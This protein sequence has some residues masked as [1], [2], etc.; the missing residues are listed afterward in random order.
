MGK[1]LS[2]QQNE[3]YQGIDQILFEE[4]DPIGIKEF[5]GPRDEYYA[6]LPLVFNLALE[7]A[8]ELQIAEYLCNYINENIGLSSSVEANMKVAAK[9]VELKTKVGL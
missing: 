5:E 9:I 2:P 7:N 4:W 1:K 3:L 6:Y 8:T